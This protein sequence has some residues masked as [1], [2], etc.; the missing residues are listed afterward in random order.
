MDMP[1]SI[2]EARAS[3]DAALQKYYAAKQANAAAIAPSY[4]HLWKTL[5]KVSGAGGKR[6]RPYM[7]LLAYKAYGG[8]QDILAVAAAWEL[9]HVCLLVH[10]DIIDRDYV[11]HGQP[12]IAGAYLKTY[13]HSADREHYAN[14]AALIGGDLALT[15]AYDLVLQSSLSSEQKL[16]AMQA[17][18]DCLF[19]E[20]GGELLDTESV[21]HPVQQVD[22]EKIAYLKTAKYSFIDP[23]A[24]G[25][26]LADAS[27]QE[28]AKI[29][30]FGESVGIGFQLADDLLG[31]FGDQKVTGK[32]ATGDLREGKRT[33][34]LQEIM[35]RATATERDRLESIIGRPDVTE[36]EA[37]YIRRLAASNGAKQAV[38]DR[39]AHHSKQSATSLS[40]L[41]IPP[42]FHDA[43]QQLATMA[44]RRTH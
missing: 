35:N 41:T 40:T 32:S 28:L 43:L 30:A 21:M 5:A 25:A 23:L 39:I 7:I 4:E 26:R 33:M 36:S 42:A 1:P 14:S 22:A 12:N 2:A 6:L 20:G 24:L 34:L 11:R 10:D 18:C 3:I 29:E 38:E 16:V 9:L 31:M 15:G 13:A 8:K 44:L 37:G 17:F 27:K 19:V